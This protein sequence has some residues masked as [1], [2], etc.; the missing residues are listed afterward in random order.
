MDVVVKDKIKVINN[1]KLRDLTSAICN[2]ISP[3]GRVLVRA[4]GTESKIR[5]MVEHQNLNKAK[6]YAKEIKSFVLKI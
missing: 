1:E 4:S 2:K 3:N 6:K 5:I